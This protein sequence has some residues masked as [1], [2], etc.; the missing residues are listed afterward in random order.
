MP[1][2][3]V[4]VLL[5]GLPAGDEITVHPAFDTTTF[6][7][8][9]MEPIGASTA[10]EQLAE[11]AEPYSCKDIAALVAKAQARAIPVAV[12]IRSCGHAFCA[13][14][15]LFHVVA[16]KFSCPVCRAGSGSTVALARHCPRIAPD[17][18]RAIAALA[19][20]SRLRTAREREAEDRELALFESTISFESI[21]LHELLTDVVNFFVAFQIRTACPADDVGHIDLAMV[22]LRHVSVPDHEDVWEIPSTTP[23]V[24]TSGTYPV[25]R[26]VST[27]LRSSTWFSVKLAVNLQDSIVDLY[28]SATT[29]YPA[30]AAGGN[31]TQEFSVGDR[32]DRLVL[33][34]DTTPYH[35]SVLLKRIEYHSCVAH[36]LPLV[37]SGFG[38]PLPDHASSGPRG[39]AAI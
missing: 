32:G 22:P 33:H 3:A 5:P 39:D 14:P 9:A 20:E 24:T 12:R 6:C 25:S 38:I 21:G 30:T 28:E 2:R 26:P 10:G 8:L 37:V 16:D 19:R 18:W 29:A 17:M 36:V 13:I 34:Y 15:F 4:T 11:I 23:I 7:T 31:M 35:D 1:T 27:L